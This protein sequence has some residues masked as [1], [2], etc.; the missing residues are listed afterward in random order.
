MTAVEIAGGFLV[1]FLVGVG[2]AL[3]YLRWQMK[4][5]IGNLEEQMGAL[6]DVSDEMTEDLGELEGPASGQEESEKEE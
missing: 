6:M 2:A 5:Q 1:G 3:F 4:R